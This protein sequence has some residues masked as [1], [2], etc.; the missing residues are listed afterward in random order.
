MQYHK[1]ATNLSQCYLN[2]FALKYDTGE[3]KTLVAY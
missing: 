1:A 3:K 2:I